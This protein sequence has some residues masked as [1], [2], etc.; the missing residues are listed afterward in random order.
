MN[1]VIKTEMLNVIIM[2]ISMRTA[3]DEILRNKK[4]PEGEL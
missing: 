4:P 2:A 3:K 1:K